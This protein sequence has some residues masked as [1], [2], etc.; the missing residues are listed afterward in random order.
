MGYIQ[1]CGERKHKITVCNGYKPNG[2]KRMLARIVNVPKEVP[3][4][5]IRQYVMGEAVVPRLVYDYL[6]ELLGHTAV[7][8]H[9]DMV[10]PCHSAHPV[11]DDQHRFALKQTEAGGLNSAFVLHVQRSD[12]LVQ[13]H[14]RRSSRSA[15]G[16]HLETLCPGTPSGR[17]PGFSPGWRWIS[18]PWHILPVTALYNSV[19]TS[20]TQPFVKTVPSNFSDAGFSGHTNLTAL[21]DK[22]ERPAYNLLIPLMVWRECYEAVYGCGQPA[23][24]AEKNHRAGAGH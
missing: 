22:A 9:H 6:G 4:R 2:Q 8:Q 10:G 15:A 16:R 20:L 3:K 13:Q 5:G 7:L 24:Q 18:L 11:G 17:P 1:Q 23:P 12:G 21:I 14:H 19:I